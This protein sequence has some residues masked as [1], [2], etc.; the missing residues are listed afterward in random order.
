V[1]ALDAGVDADALLDALAAVATGGLPQALE[2]LV[3][4]VGRRHGHVR[5]APAGSVVCAD[6]A[7]LL[8]ELVATKSLRAL[9]LRAVAPTVLVS[10]A[11]PDATLAAL[12]EAGYAPTG[13]T[14][15]GSAR[16]ERRVR[17]RATVPTSHSH[18]GGLSVDAEAVAKRLLAAPIALSSVPAGVPA[19]ARVSVPARAA[20]SG[21]A[22]AS[23]RA[24]APPEQVVALQAEA[25]SA[26]ERAVLV[27]AIET[28]APVR[29]DYVS[30]TG[31]PST[32]V[33]ENA[34]LT[35]DAVIAWCRLR[36]AE[37]MFIL[38]RIQTVSPA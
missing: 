30:A 27:D 4:D 10:A 19:P 6:D 1:T 20:A 22:A 23:A 35:G 24:A 34:E 5:V 13:L 7:T 18:N 15:G 3:R 31:R 37:R 21:R 38:S 2:Y 17:R 29:I 25:L 28:G 26:A 36:A 12:R 9:R 14:E 8:A 32:R 16:V 11:D 33:I